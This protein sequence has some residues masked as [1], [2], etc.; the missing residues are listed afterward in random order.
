MFS[1]PFQL[2]FRSIYLYKDIAELNFKKY[3]MTCYWSQLAGTQ[4]SRDSTFIIYPFILINL[5][6]PH[7]PCSD[8]NRA[9]EAQPVLNL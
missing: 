1:M 2:E 7:V 3:I 4:D 5:Y 8:L 6:I 9:S